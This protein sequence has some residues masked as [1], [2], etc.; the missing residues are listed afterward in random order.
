MVVTDSRHEPAHFL[1]AHIFSVL[2]E[3]ARI[4]NLVILIPNQFP[5]RPLHAMNSTKITVADRLNLYTWFPFQLR[6]CGVVKDV[7]LLDE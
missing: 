3:L 1:A 6:R 2:R 5:Y 7:A 4:D